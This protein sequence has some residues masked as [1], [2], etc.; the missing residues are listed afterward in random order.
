MVDIYCRFIRIDSA[1]LQIFLAATTI[2][3]LKSFLFFVFSIMSIIQALRSNVGGKRSIWHALPLAPPDKIIGKDPSSCYDILTIYHLTF[4]SVTGLNEMF[5]ADTCPKK[6]NLG[7]GA[8]RDDQGKTYILPSI[9][10]AE[11]SIVN[12]NMDK[13]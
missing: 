2:V 13:E 10:E 1:S 8:Y 3:A 12:S 9:R 11:L 4:C 6:V 5:K 7:V